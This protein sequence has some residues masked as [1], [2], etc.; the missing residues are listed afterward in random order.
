M[1]ESTVAVERAMVAIRRSQSRRAMGRQA[2]GRLGDG[3]GV[4]PSVFGVLD[5]IEG[6]DR[7]ATVTEVGA[8]LGVD[9]PRASRLVA[10]A[11][12]EGLVVR[13]ADQ[14]DGRRALLSL[15]PRATAQLEAVHGFR[16][17]VFAAAMADWT[18]TD[19]AAFARLITAFVASWSAVT[20]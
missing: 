11:V 2:M 10:R 4:D 14:R 18:D 5:A 6:L 19:R 15:T 12:A 7:P 9:Q 20:G 8:R 3:A 1:D 17:G 16:Q 13:A